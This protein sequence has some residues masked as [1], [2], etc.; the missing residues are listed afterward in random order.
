MKRSTPRPN[1]CRARFLRITLAV[2]T[3]TFA[4]APYAD[5]Q[6]IS[7]VTLNYAVSVPIA[8]VVP[9]TCTGGYVLVTGT[10]NLAITTILAGQVPFA[11]TVKYTS[12]GTGQDVLADGTL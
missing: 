10:T 3:V 7:P 11:V 4:V 8:K 6:L 1:G 5:A 2:L 12:S 9:N